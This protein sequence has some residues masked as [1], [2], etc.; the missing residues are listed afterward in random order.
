M[1]WKSDA[2]QNY[3]SISLHYNDPYRAGFGHTWQGDEP[4][5][6]SLT[7]NDPAN[8]IYVYVSAK[9]P[10]C[11]VEYSIFEFT[12]PDTRIE[13]GL[14][15]NNW[16]DLVVPRKTA[17][18]RNNPPWPNT[19]NA[20]NI[21]LSPYGPSSYSLPQG[22]E[23]RRQD[24]S[25]IPPG[26]P[27]PIAGDAAG[28][29]LATSPPTAAALPQNLTRASYPALVSNQW[30]NIISDDRM[31]TMPAPLGEYT[32]IWDLRARLGHRVVVVD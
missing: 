11:K 4:P 9:P 23:A 12:D 31:A 7:C 27:N 22:Y 30:L 19:I 17:T 3:P 6:Q 21:N 15:N 10:V 20:S 29:R 32:F 8:G 1:G 25:S 16:V 2:Y 26:I 24:G 14:R 18:T 28:R 5:V 13:I